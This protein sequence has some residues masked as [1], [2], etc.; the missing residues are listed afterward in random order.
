[1]ADPKG[2][3]GGSLGSWPSP[4]LNQNQTIGFFTT[5]QHKDT[6]SLQKKK[7]QKNHSE[8]WIYFTFVKEEIGLKVR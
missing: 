7:L 2:G 5:K 4:S 8:E 3:T 1:M 6:K